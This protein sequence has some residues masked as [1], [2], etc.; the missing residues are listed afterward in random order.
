MRPPTHYSEVNEIA[1]R[2]LAGVTTALGDSFVA[3]YLGGSL[4]TGTFKPQTSD[5]DFVVITEREIADDLAA[6]LRR[7]HERITTHP[8]KWAQKLE[9][10]YVPRDAARTHGAIAQRC[11]YLGVGGWFNVGHYQ[12]DWIVQLHLVREHGIVIAGPDPKTLIDP[13]TPDELRAS[14]AAIMRDWE[15]LLSQPE[16]FDAEYQVYTVLTMCRVLYTLEHGAVVPKA[17]AAAW[18]KERQAGQWGR[19]IDEAVSWCH[20]VPFDHLN[21]VLDLLRHRIKRACGERTF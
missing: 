21:Q 2:L 9:G 13:V 14:C 3:M 18:A 17:A 6:P 12:S 20:G 19:L 5:V 4:A 8:S 7:A 16:R 15:A 11:A 1:S 10:L